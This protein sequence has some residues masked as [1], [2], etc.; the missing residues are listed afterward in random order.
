MV[1]VTQSTWGV[2]WLVAL[3]LGAAGAG[4][5]GATGGGHSGGSAGGPAS[6]CLTPDSGTPITTCYFDLTA[7]PSSTQTPASTVLNGGLFRVPFSGLPVGTGVFQPFVRIQGPASGSHG[8]DDDDRS[9]HGSSSGSGGVESGFNTDANVRLLDNLDRGGTNWNHSI[10]LSEIPIVE[11]CDNGLPTGTNCRLYREFLLDI[12]EPGNPESG[13]SLD[14]FKLY[15]AST[16]D[17]TAN[18]ATGQCAPD[19]SNGGSFALC[20]AAKIYDMDQIPGGDASLLL[21]YRNHHGSGNGVDLQAMIPVENF[22]GA[23]PGSF[24]YL[25]SKFGA[26]GERCRS[27][28]DDD[29]DDHHAS[30]GGSPCQTPGGPVAGRA[31]NLN[32]GAEA[33]FEEWGLRRGR[34]SLPSTLVIFAVGLLALAARR[35]STSL[36]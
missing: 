7:L 34:V 31:G 17:L 12:N 1:K 28:G 14:E 21:D 4:Q 20:G 6:S 8:D 3:A 25:Y 16:G 11:V 19:S 9:G 33:G 29:D 26:T 23:T 30:S 13:L 32:Y 35:R 24:I 27:G 10:R 2:T 36:T 22:G 18:S 5:A 15:V